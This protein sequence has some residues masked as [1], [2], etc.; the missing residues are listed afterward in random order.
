M[1]AL[2]FISFFVSVLAVLGVLVVASRHAH[3][4]DPDAPQRFHAGH[5][6]RVGGAG[7]LL[8]LAAGWLS[9]ACFGRDVFNVTL[10]PSLALAALACLLPA[11]LGGIADDVTQR[12][13]PRWRLLLTILSALLGCLL[14]NLTL[15][16][17]GIPWLDDRLVRWPFVAG[18][19]AVVAMGGLPHAF[20][21]IDGYNG[22][23][24]TVTLF[25]C[26]ALAHV[27]L[28]V[29]DR[30]LAA[31][32]LCLAG[33]T[34][35]FLF[36]NYPRGLIF[37][38]DG[39]A[40]LWGVVIAIVSITLVQR[41]AQVSPWFPM[42][43]LM[44]PVSETLFS[45]YRKLARGQSPG[46]PDALHFHQ[47]VFRRVVRGTAVGDDT[48]TMLM[49]NNRT[50]PYLWALAL[51]TVFPALLFWRNTPL[52]IAACC[53]FAMAY[54]ALYVAIVRFK[55]PHWLRK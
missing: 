12:L 42:L 13:S 47:L 52:L 45:I 39:G 24:A 31:M 44:Y 6:P 48:R 15:T 1:I 16:R 46:S 27:S 28:Q 50:S 3:H 40:Y 5:V 37:A 38:G 19:F 9:A 25:I 4:Y 30:Q 34:A 26:V 17:V 49:R 43:L 55:V 18:L 54:V 2:V 53:A 33:A 11:V 10:A 14:L 20:N 29:G 36:W 35:G 8:G 51:F 32:I 7:M 41:H 21:L 22:L 23:A